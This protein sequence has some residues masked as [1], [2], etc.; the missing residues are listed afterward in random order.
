M[1]TGINHITLAVRDSDETFEFYADTLGLR[2]IQK[3]S[4]SAYLR[5]TWIALTKDCTM[6]KNLKTKRFYIALMVA[7]GIVCIFGMVFGPISSQTVGASDW[8]DAFRNGARGDY[9]RVVTPYWSL[10]LSLLP[11][12]FPEPLGYLIWISAGLFLVLVTAQ[13]FQ[14]P[15]L[16]VLLS[17]QMNWIVFYG[18]ID[19][20][21]IFGVGLGY[22]AIVN[23]KPYLLG[24]ALALVTI[25]PQVGLLLAAYFFFSSSSK[26]KTTLT[27]LLIVLLSLL[28]WPK[29]P[30]RFIFEQM[31]SFM[32][33]PYN[34]WANTSLEIP[35]WLGAIISLL[36]LI[37]PMTLEQ[38][39]P[40]LLATNLFIS[41]YSTIYSQLSLLS[42]GLPYLFSIFGF[43]PWVVAII[44]GPFGTWQWAFVFPLSVIIYSYY[45]AYWKDV[46][47]K[48]KTWRESKA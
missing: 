23:K 12:Q 18:Q 45:A 14:S 30:E 38:K 48:I 27:F 8:R 24:V 3:N 26:P 22:D 9:S 21:I 11:A 29:W 39:I 5:D 25:K 10:F 15:L 34:S 47:T 33:R 44:A 20:F 31:L 19:P 13:R 41:P 28:V 1:I 32:D 43:I 16:A 7:G 35:Y 17:Y 2:R 37:S 6:F 42:V 46:E 4:I 40:L 36:A